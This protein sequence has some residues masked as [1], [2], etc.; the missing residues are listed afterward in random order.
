MPFISKT[1]AVT[2]YNQ[3]EKSIVIENKYLKAVTLIPETTG[4]GNAEFFGQ[5]FITSGDT[6]HPVHVALI[7]QG[8][9]GAS[10]GISWTGSIFMAP[11]YAVAARIFSESTIPVRCN[12]LAQEQP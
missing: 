10:N 8:Y 11:A 3:D 4:S 1:L 6:P 9:F 5:I 12:I 2:A 7:A